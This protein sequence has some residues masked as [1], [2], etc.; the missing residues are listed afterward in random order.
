MLLLRGRNLEKNYLTQSRKAA[1][2]ERKGSLLN[3][4]LCAFAPL[5]ET[6]GH[7]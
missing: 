6:T 2:K 7:A 5:R 4:F 1:K 3:G